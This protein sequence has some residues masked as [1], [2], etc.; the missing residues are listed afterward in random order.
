MKDASGI[1]FQLRPNKL[2]ESHSP[3]CRAC[4]AIAQKATADYQGLA[5]PTYSW[6]SAV[7]DPELRPKGAQSKAAPECHANER[8]QL[9]KYAG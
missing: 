8:V 5:V 4:P 6:T 2:G 3:I 7:F 1:R 9:E